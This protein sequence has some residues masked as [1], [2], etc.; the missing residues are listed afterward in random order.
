MPYPAKPRAADLAK[1]SQRTALA[2]AEL[3]MAFAPALAA[4]ALSLAI[5]AAATLT[6]GFAPPSHAFLACAAP[7]GLLALGLL[8]RTLVML[9]R[10]AFRWLRRGGP[11]ARP[12]RGAL[13]KSRRT[14]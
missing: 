3:R 12:L 9:T 8:L 11:A 13:P 6:G 10:T 7:F 14:V 1:H 5:L 4:A 2:L